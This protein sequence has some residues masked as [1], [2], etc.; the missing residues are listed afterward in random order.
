MTYRL[1]RVV[2]RADADRSAFLLSY[3]LSDRWLLLASAGL[4]AFG[5]ALEGI[6]N[7]GE[8]TRTRAPLRRHGRRL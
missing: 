4:P 1:G 8:F 2:A 5:A 7:Q 3:L 6:N